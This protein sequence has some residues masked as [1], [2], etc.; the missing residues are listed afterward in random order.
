M[1]NVSLLMKAQ[2]DGKNVPAPHVIFEGSYQMGEDWHDADERPVPAKVSFSDMIQ[3][4][5]SASSSSGRRSLVAAPVGLHQRGS[6]VPACVEHGSKPLRPFGVT[7][8][9]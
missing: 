9:G 6:L 4:T 2:A 3:Q 7:A 1:L 8:R 5:S